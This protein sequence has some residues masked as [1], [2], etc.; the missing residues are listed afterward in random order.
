[1]VYRASPGAN[2]VSQTEGDPSRQ[3]AARLKEMLLTRE[4]VVGLVKEFHLYPDQVRRSGLLDAAEDMRK[5]HLK[6]DSGGGDTF[7]ISF[8][9]ESPQRAQ[10]VTARAAEMLLDVHR[11]WRTQDAVK[12]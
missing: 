4:R 7:R 9:D 3:L 6:F 12:T 8:E 1:L 2:I 10:L 5:Q 11:T